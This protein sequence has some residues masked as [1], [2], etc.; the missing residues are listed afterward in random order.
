MSEDIPI[1]DTVYTE[2]LGASITDRDRIAL[3]ILV[4]GGG[5]AAAGLGGVM[6]GKARIEVV[7][8]RLGELDRWYRDYLETIVQRLEHLAGGQPIRCGTRKQLRADLVELA[9]AFQVGYLHHAPADERAGA[10]LRVHHAADFEFLIS[11]RD[12]VRVDHQLFGEH[13]NRRQFLTGR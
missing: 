3:S 1:N 6:T 7:R 12:R 4:V 11:P 13:A 8:A 2:V 5:G 10:H 9:P